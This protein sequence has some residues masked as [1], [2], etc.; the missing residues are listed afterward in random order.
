M[1]APDTRPVLARKIAAHSGVGMRPEEL[2]AQ[3]D[4]A[5][6]RAVRRAGAP[7]EGFGI[8]LDGIDIGLDTNL[9]AAIDA[10]P[11]HGL[12]AATEDMEGRRGLLALEHTLV[13]A[14]IEVQT[15]GRVEEGQGPPRAVTRIDE[16]LCADFIDLMY[17]ALA[18]EG[19]GINGRSWPERMR[20][21]SR[22]KDRSQINLLLPARGYHLLQANVTAAGLKTG[23]LMI[24]LPT[25]PAL[26]RKNGK[27]PEAKPPRPDSWKADML[28]ALGPAPL[29]LN[30]VLMRVDMPLAK[31][32]ALQDGDLIPF[33]RADL[34][35]VTLES[36]G[37]HVFARG[38]LGQIG[39]RRAVRLADPNGLAETPGAEAGLRA[40]P[41]APGPPSARSPGSGDLA[42]MS[43]EA[44]VA[45]AGQPAQSQPVAAQMAPAPTAAQPQPGTPEDTGAALEK[46]MAQADPPAQ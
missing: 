13:D 1:S 18:F 37:G 12:I 22:I 41:P 11:D 31:V 2:S 3:L 35:A 20:Y 26:G 15:T 28:A 34:S 5:L 21:G 29:A 46:M 24:L 44:R 33:D 23:K 7:M 32:E 8:S 30:A 39:G 40:A 16:A 27:R 36:E 17:G 25:D 38:K 42:A 45:Q 43:M 10:F 9:Q 6:S 19:N 14:L 4:V